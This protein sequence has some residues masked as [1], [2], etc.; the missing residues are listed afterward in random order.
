MFTV[1]LAARVLAAAFVVGGGL[2]HLWL[3]QDGYRAVPKVGTSFL[4]NAAASGV[5]AVAL[6]VFARGRTA[7]A[8]SV[9]AVLFSIASAGALV[10]SRTTGFLGFTEKVWSDQSIQA[11]TAELGAVVAVALILVDRAR[12]SRP[13][14]IP[15]PVD[16]DRRA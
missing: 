1:G 10:L 7:T 6:V 14:L 8:V 13:E 4:L 9:I 2:V 12:R 3:W 15:I 16:S 5:V 11:F